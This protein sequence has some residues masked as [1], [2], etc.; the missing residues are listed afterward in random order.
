[1][2]KDQTRKILSNMN[3]SKNNKK[4]YKQKPNNKTTNYKLL[5]SNLR[6]LTA[7]RR[8]LRNICASDLM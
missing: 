4:H 2:K 6:Q 1:M 3:N 5:I 8:S 7:K